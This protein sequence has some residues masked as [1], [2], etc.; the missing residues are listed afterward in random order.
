MLRNWS[1]SENECLKCVSLLLCLKLVLLVD[2]RKEEVL[3]VG[4]STPAGETS[5]ELD[6]HPVYPSVSVILFPRVARGHPQL[7]SASGHPEHG[8]GERLLA[9]LGQQKECGCRLYIRFS[10][11]LDEIRWLH[12]SHSYE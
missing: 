3:A 11:T 8:S 6:D 7:V 10:P 2:A 1:V 9:R 4:I 12:R 5:V